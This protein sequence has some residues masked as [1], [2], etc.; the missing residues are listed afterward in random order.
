MGNIIMALFV[1]AVFRT[2]FLVIKAILAIHVF[3]IISILIT[4]VL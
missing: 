1:W 3:K 2:A 4:C